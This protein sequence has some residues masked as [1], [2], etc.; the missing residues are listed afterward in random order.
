MRLDYGLTLQQTQKLIMTPELRQAIAVLQMS[1]L[2]LNEFV[3][4]QLEENPL[5]ETNDFENYDEAAGNTDASD[6]NTSDKF[7]VDWQEYFQDSSDLGFA[8]GQTEYNQKES[9]FESFT[10]K[11]PT[12]VEHL[13]FQLALANCS[14]ELETIVKYLIGNLDHWGYLKIG[15]EETAREL[16]APLQKV[17]DALKVLQAMEPAGV[18]ARNLEECLLLQVEHLGLQNPLLKP[19]IADYLPDLAKGRL[20]KIA[21]LLGQPVSEV[22]KAVD[23]L[24]SLDPKPGRNFTHGSDTRYIV[25][26]VVV[27]KV[28]GE[29]IILVNDISAPR[30]RVNNAYRSV[31]MQGNNLDKDTR[32][33]V[34]Q[35][36]NSAL[37]LL[38]SIEQ[39][40]LTLY[41]V[42][43]AL[44]ELQRDFLEHG[45]KYLKPLNLKDVAER[46]ELHEST[47][48]RATS[49]KY[50]QTPLG[51]FEMK[52]FFSTGLKY[53]DGEQ[54]S[55]ESIK[56]LLKEIINTEDPKKP[57][58]DQKIANLM[59]QKGI[60]ISR[61]TVAK[62]RDEMAIPAAAQRKRY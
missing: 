19:I 50:M 26:D 46:V 3:E 21:S 49:N 13:T 14:A 36:L 59:K 15:V 53:R 10:S 4:Q 43:K 20:E 24:R 54:V 44:V 17:E 29:Y 23:E 60:K 5:L 18:G 58:S 55:A 16:K 22:Q 37:W 1:S 34:E 12:L 25:P 47:V 45:V 6:A 11:A 33:Y 57:L 7:D 52:Y 8:K 9:S 56:N 48:S 42:A 51:V 31:I 35:K 61:R 30:I 28:E 40:R 41:K 27:E 2:E 39:R 32:K 38:R 62:Y